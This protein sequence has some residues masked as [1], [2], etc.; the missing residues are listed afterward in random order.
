MTPNNHAVNEPDFD[1]LHQ[2]P[3]HLRHVI[4][5]SKLLAYAPRDEETPKGV[6]GSMRDM[7]QLAHCYPS[8]L[9]HTFVLQI[10]FVYVISNQDQRHGLTNLTS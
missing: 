2:T 8:T 5:L 1:L 4:F 7:L 9:F 3:F 10:Q 6:S